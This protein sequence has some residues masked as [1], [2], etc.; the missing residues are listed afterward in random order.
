MKGEKD[1]YRTVDDHSGEIDEKAGLRRCGGQGDILA[2]AL[3]TTLHW[4]KLV[5]VSIAEACVAS[6]FLVR[7]LSNKAFEKIGRSV[8]APDMI[9]E[10]PDTLRNIERV[11][12][13]HD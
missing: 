7:Y 8:E 9:S 2:G 4:A 10:I 12:F 11:Y 5:N 1:Y 3:G 13:R 6:S